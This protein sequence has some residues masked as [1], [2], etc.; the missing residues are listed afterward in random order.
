[1]K[2]ISVSLAFILIFLFVGLFFSIFVQAAEW[3]SAAPSSLVPC[4]SG[5]S[6]SNKCTLCH[7]IVGFHNIFQYGLFMVI[8]LAFVA[9]VIAGIMYIVSTGDEGL[10]KAAKGFLKA[11]LVGFT[12]VVGAWLLVNI[13]IWLIASPASGLQQRWFRLECVATPTTGGAPIE[14]TPAAGG[15]GGGFEGGGGEFGGGGASGSF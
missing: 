4:G 10:M 1:M 5:S 13:V 3:P 14:S 15:S 8:V 2:K 6:I 11:A 12:F 9:I 7:L